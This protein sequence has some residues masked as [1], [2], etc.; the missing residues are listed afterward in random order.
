MCKTCSNMTGM[1]L[2]SLLNPSACYL[3]ALQYLN[4]IKAIVL[5]LHRITLISP[6][7]KQ[8]YKENDSW[9]LQVELPSLLK[10]NREPLEPFPN[11]I[12]SSM[13]VIWS[14]TS[15][16]PPYRNSKAPTFNSGGSN[17]TW[18]HSSLRAFNFPAHT[19]MRIFNVRRNQKSKGT[20]YQHKC[21]N[22]NMTVLISGE[23][24]L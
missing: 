3:H 19:D 23:F 9:S 10:T 21:R 14:L 18:T 6:A 8:F 4:A 11:R 15:L 13:Y 17:I 1:I 2:R 22:G 20:L 24:H 12:F 5:D 7:L 16:S